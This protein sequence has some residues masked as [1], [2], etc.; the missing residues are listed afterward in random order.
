MIF[1]SGQLLRH[2]LPGLL[3]AATAFTSAGYPQSYYKNSSVLATG[4]WV[5]ITVDGE[6][7]F[8]VSYDDLR[9]WGFSDPSKVSVFGYSPLADISGEF[10]DTHVDDLPMTASMH[11]ADGRILFYGESDAKMHIKGM[12]A[13]SVTRNYYDRRGVYFLSDS[14]PSKAVPVTSYKPSTQ[15][16]RRAHYHLEF[17]EN[18]AHNPGEGG[19]YYHDTP[20]EPGDS[21]T[22]TFHIKDFAPSNSGL[23]SEG[24]F[25]YDFAR[26]SS[27]RSHLT[28]T[29]PTNVNTTYSNDGDCSANTNSL[30]YTPGYGSVYFKPLDTSST[31]LQDED[32]S[33]TVTNTPGSNIVYTAIDRATLCYPRSSRLGDERQLLM[34][35]YQ[36]VPSG[37]RFEISDTPANTVAWNV[38]NPFNITSYEVRRDATD[39][40]GAMRIALPHVYNLQTG[41]C[42]IVVFAPDAAHPSATYA[43]EVANTNIHGSETPEMVI[44]TTATL[45]SEARR[46][47]ALHE[48]YQGMKVGVFVQDD[49]FNEFSSGVSTP[50][51]YRR[52][53]KMF[54]DREPDVLKYLLLYGSGSW[55][56]RGIVIEP[57]DRLLTFQAELVDHARDA[58]RNY[59]TDQ[60]FGMVADDYDPDNIHYTPAQIVVGRMNL[61]TPVQAQS[62]NT[63]I[64]QFFNNS[65]TAANYLRAIISSDQGNSNAHFQQS[66]ESGALLAGKLPGMTLTRGHVVLYPT[67]DEITDA[68]KVLMQAFERGQG[69]FAYCGHGS[70][71]K[72]TGVNLLT[73]GQ[74]NEEPFDTPCFAFLSS[75]DMFCFDR[76]TSLMD[77]LLATTRGGII[78]GVGA[79]RSVYL[80]YNQNIYLAVCDEYAS[81]VPG[82]T[83]GQL[84][85]QGRNKLV[86]SGGLSSA[87]VT[88]ALCYNYI[89]DPALPMPVPGYKVVIDRINGQ[90]YD[91][92]ASVALPPLSKVRISGHIVRNDGK[93]AS[94]FNGTGLLEV[95]DTP[96]KSAEVTVGSGDKVENVSTTLDH[97]PVHENVF[98]VSGGAFEFDFVLPELNVTGSVNRMVLTAK[99]TET[100]DLAAGTATNAAVT[101]VADDFVPSLDPSAPEITAFYIDSPDFRAGDTTG[102]KFTVHAEITPPESGIH[103]AKSGLG[104]T[105]GLTFDV[106]TKYTDL[107]NTATYTP[108]GNLL[109]KKDFNNVVDGHHSLSLTVN[110]N[111]G[112]TSTA[113]LEFYTISGE[114]SGTLTCESDVAATDPSTTIVRRTAE[115]D[116]VHE[117]ES[118]PDCRL[119]IFDSAG[120]TVFTKSGVSFPFSWDLRGNDGTAVA[121]G[122]YT[123]KVMLRSGTVYGATA[124]VG[125]TVIK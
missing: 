18:E 84:F 69:L 41:P 39:G 93:D 109:I 91:S 70:A 95:Y 105:L 120:N 23:D 123:A 38:D 20:M 16:I 78:G 50:M 54:Y 46:L 119:L 121:D 59:T 68:H 106:S 8:Q 22:Y 26:N 63:K 82:T 51:A 115:L 101:D 56:N 48:Q 104:T 30:L 1:P 75:C 36:A 10:T 47:A 32:V 116:L 107:F 29:L 96:T 102:P 80:E 124:P 113:D 49:I 37:Q 34:H 90:A 62:A 122:R 45:E 14:Q 6:G 3:C 111:L 9:A 85:T 31:S 108:E 89:G 35:I 60:V 98:S 21:R 11:T 40:P 87:R 42:R 15:S 67:T 66:E 72:I 86:T 77:A 71:P 4:H 73:I 33:F 44:I 13:T 92:S 53:V 17:I 74:V 2:L 88:N 99:D 117:H 7:I 118:A 110:N 43:G 81:A 100:G 19:V 94:G 12:K 65:P 79:C 24:Y 55:D 83:Y 112:K 76:S 52:M 58:H 103:I 125:F 64:E 57:T 114:L 25:R 27:S 28:T 61:T 97:T 5:K